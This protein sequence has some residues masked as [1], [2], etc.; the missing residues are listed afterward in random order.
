MDWLK[1]PLNLNILIVYIQRNARGGDNSFQARA[2]TQ[3]NQPSS[4]IA[5]VQ[6]F[7]CC[8]DFLNTQSRST[9]PVLGGAML[10]FMA[11]NIKDLGVLGNRSSD[12]VVHTSI[13]WAVDTC[14]LFFLCFWTRMEHIDAICI[15]GWSLFVHLWM[16]IDWAVHSIRTAV[17]DSDEKVRRNGW[18]NV[19]SVLF[20]EN[21]Y[22]F[23][24]TT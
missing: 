16:P 12:H 10:G 7:E 6:R 2:G 14:K 15:Q 17:W 5:T 4:R 20:F 19:L 24:L 22:I 23:F 13:S 8:R 11:Q 1:E 18:S 3:S 9:I 21:S